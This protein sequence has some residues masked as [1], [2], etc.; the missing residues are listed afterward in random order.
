MCRSFG[1]IR[2]LHKFLELLQMYSKSVQADFRDFM[3]FI[4]IFGNLRKI[5]KSLKNFGK[6]PNCR[7]SSRVFGNLQKLVRIGNFKKCPKQSW[8]HFSQSSEI[9][10]KSSETFKKLS[11]VMEIFV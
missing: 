5:R 7:E 1:K 4:E 9:F 8:K 3:N 10:I 6:H 11:D 2:N